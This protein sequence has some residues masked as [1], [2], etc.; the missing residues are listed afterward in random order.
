MSAE[1]AR[2]AVEVAIPAGLRLARSGWGFGRRSL[3]Q[4]RRAPGSR[5][6]GGARLRPRDGNSDGADRRDGEGRRP[7][8][9]RAA[10]RDVLRRCCTSRGTPSRHWTCRSLATI[11]WSKPGRLAVMGAH[12]PARVLSVNAPPKCANSSVWRRRSGPVLTRPET[13]GVG[14]SGGCHHRPRGCAIE[15][16][17]PNASATRSV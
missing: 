10:L 1:P 3:S 6:N 17:Q 9:A 7:C 13:A 15:T 4:L 12:T 2:T 5:R 14:R 16:L 11:R 8:R